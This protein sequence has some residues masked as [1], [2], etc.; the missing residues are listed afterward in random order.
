MKVK[1]LHSEDKDAIKNSVNDYKKQAISFF[2]IAKAVRMAQ[3]LSSD[4]DHL[5]QEIHDLMKKIKEMDYA[6]AQL[7]DIF[8]KNNA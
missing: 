5:R 3:T 8:K 7:K 4:T 6:Q 2:Q 1:K